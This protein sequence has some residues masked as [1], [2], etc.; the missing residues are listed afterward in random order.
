M[1]LPLQLRAIANVTQV[2]AP[3]LA[4]VQADPETMARAAEIESV[5]AM[6]DDP[7]PEREQ[8][9]PEDYAAAGISSTGQSSMHGSEDQR[10]GRSSR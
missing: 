1:A 9:E 4:L 5:L 7:V 8:G 6:S 2:L 3:R 10:E